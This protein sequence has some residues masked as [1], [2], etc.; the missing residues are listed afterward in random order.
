MKPMKQIANYLQIVW[1]FDWS[2]NKKI[3]ESFSKAMVGLGFDLFNKACLGFH[4]ANNRCP[5]SNISSCWWRFQPVFVLLIP[6]AIEACY[7]LYLVYH[8]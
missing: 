7:V 3:D 4:K 8:L 6:L 1:K 5:V 2:D